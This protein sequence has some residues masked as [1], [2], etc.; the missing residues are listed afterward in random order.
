MKINSALI[1][2]ALLCGCSKQSDPSLAIKKWE[3]KVATVENTEHYYKKQHQE[4]ATTNSVDGH[5]HMRW[6]DADP[7]DVSLDFA[8]G[9]NYGTD[10]N[11]YGSDGW[12]LVST[13]PMLETIPDAGYTEYDKFTNIRVG[14]VILIFKRPSTK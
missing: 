1:L 6:D 12:E 9:K 5:L 10:L 11:D 8:Y 13:I 3:Y 14:K 2:A 4:E 7:G